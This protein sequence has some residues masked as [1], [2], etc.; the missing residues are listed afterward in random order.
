[1]VLDFAPYATHPL[2]SNDVEANVPLKV[3]MIADLG[4]RGGAL[5]AVTPCSAR[6]DGQ[7]AREALE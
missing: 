6:S 1:M 7:P 5:E 4:T 2:L 3:G